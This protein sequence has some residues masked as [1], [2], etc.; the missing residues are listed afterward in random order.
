MYQHTTRTAS[1]NLNMG[2]EPCPG[3]SHQCECVDM[4]LCP[5]APKPIAL[6]TWTVVAGMNGVKNS[7][8]KVYRMQKQVA[9]MTPRI[10][11]G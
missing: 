11:I 2:L 7:L 5:A 9:T 10:N 4:S 3:G 8:G 1:D 6:R